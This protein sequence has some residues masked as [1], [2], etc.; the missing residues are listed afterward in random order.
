MFCYHH[1]H[2]N[3]VD[4]VLKPADKWIQGGKYIISHQLYLLRGNDQ[5]PQLLQLFLFIPYSLFLS[6]KS[7]SQI[8]RPFFQS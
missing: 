7:G 3:I 1:F 6:I 4:V 8:F 2:L 5:E